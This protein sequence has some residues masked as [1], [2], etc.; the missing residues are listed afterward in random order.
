MAKGLLLSCVRDDNPCL[1][2]EPKVLYRLGSEEVPVADYTI[3]L[4]KAE[5]VRE[6]FLFD[7]LFEF[8]FY[9]CLSF[10]IVLLFI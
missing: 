2:L 8:F 3:P 7:L 10:C 6:G 1:F 9:I 5:V 4:S